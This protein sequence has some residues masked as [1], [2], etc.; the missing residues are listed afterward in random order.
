MERG[1]R[2]LNSNREVRYRAIKKVEN[3]RGKRWTSETN[4]FDLFK[5]REER[6]L[7]PLI[8]LEWIEDPH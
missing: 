8:L 3:K 7:P 5:G 2:K 1:A 4:R 6:I